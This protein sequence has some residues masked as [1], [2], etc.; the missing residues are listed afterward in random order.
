MIK[1]SEKR[2]HFMYY[3]VIGEMLFSEKSDDQEKIREDL[4]RTLEYINTY[5]KEDI[6]SD[7]IPM[8]EG[9][10]CGFFYTGRHVLEILDIIQFR[11]RKIPVRF[12]VGIGEMLTALSPSGG[13]AAGP[14][15]EYAKK[16]LN[17]LQHENDYQVSR[18]LVMADTHED[19]LSFLNESLHMCDF[20]QQ[21][22]KSLQSMIMEI[23]ILKTGY[24][25]PPKQ[26]ELAE[27]FKTSKQNINRAVRGMG[28]HQYI[29]TKRE[30]Q[31]LFC[32]Y[33]G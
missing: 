26:T 5:Y 8:E 21:R 13:N 22:W 17:S 27:I 30:M 2:G 20:V 33:W 7:L 4:M 14:A 15:Y 9:K 11:F 16:A 19:Q 18:I 24:E 10:F 23:T 32:R 28:Y 31:K 6:A 29:R 25:E 3:A 12:G 1:L